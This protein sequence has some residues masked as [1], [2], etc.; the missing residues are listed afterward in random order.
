M[1][2]ADCPRP[3]DDTG[4]SAHL[5]NE[6][7]SRGDVDLAWRMGARWF[8][9]LHIANDVWG[10]TRY[11]VERG[12]IPVMRLFALFPRGPEGTTLAD[13]LRNYRAAGGYYVKLWNETN[14]NYE[15]DDGTPD[16]TK[17][18]QVL[19]GAIE[20]TLAAGCIPVVGNL[21]PGGN[22]PDYRYWCTVLDYWRLVGFDPFNRVRGA[23]VGVH[24]Y[25]DNKF[26]AWGAGG[27]A[28]WPPGSAQDN[29]GFRN[30]EWYHDAVRERFGL[31]V[32]VMCT[33]GGPRLGDAGLEDR[34]RTGPAEH[35]QITLDIVDFIQN[36][37][38]P[39]YLLN[40]TG[41]WTFGWQSNFDA[42]NYFG[43]PLEASKQALEAYPWRPRP[44]SG[45]I[46][47]PP[48]PI[49]PP[50]VTPPVISPATPGR[51]SLVSV[52]RLTPEQNHMR[53]LIIFEPAD[54]PMLVK[55][56]D[57]ETVQTKDMWYGRGEYT[58]Q[59]ANAVS[60]V[61]TLPGTNFPDDPPY[62]NG[63]ELVP[64]NSNGHFSDVVTFEQEE[65]MSIP[66]L[67]KPFEGAYPQSQGWGENPAVYAQFG[68]PGHNGIDWAVPTGTP[69][70]AA[71]DGTLYHATDPHPTG[72]FGFYA[73]VDAPW[74]STFYA[75]LDPTGPHISGDAVR[76]GDVIGYS[77]N[78]GFS[79]GPH[80]HFGVKVAGQGAPGYGDWVDP[81]PLL[82]EESMPEPISW[83]DALTY[84]QC[85]G[86]LLEWD[87][88]IK[89]YRNVLE[90]ALRQEIAE[91]RGKVRAARATL[92]NLVAALEG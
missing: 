76:A 77:D 27:P 12:G 56:R 37:H 35:R 10:I 43:G 83:A 62:W 33:E 69:I 50:I 20:E 41:F 36:G 63:T 66:Q 89:H 22:W 48:G 11:I 80:L 46:P 39:D 32:A 31:D 84:E 15:C 1:R 79:T 51:W 44:Q 13:M 19:M 40:V 14:N 70:R 4:I 85:K 65:A 54:V 17:Y 52:R 38:A 8:I 23:V 67:R 5:G 75:H 6:T 59:V 25:C 18:A 73:R 74:G 64:G 7:I 57:G 88:V 9:Y 3:S 68:L 61:A 78:T 24:N 28:A 71:H 45:T 30:W 86:R 42:D 90:P 16:A 58:V 53:N 47:P 29:I 81:T 60:D 21:S 26:L 87:G 2:L 72:G 91:L 92:R 34:P 82:Q 55:W 49:D